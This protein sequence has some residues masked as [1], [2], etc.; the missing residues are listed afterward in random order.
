MET[1]DH[2]RALRLDFDRLRSAAAHDLSAP[3][4]ACPGWDLADLVW[5]VGEVHHFWTEIVAGEVQDPGDV[6][7]AT[8]PSADELLPWSGRVAD[9]LIDV[10]A[11][12]DP[13]VAVWTWAA[14]R[15]V[16]FVQR[17]MA[18]E[19][20]VHRWDA[21][22]AVGTPVAIDTDLATDGIDEF[23]VHMIDDGPPIEGR[24]I[25]E[26][27]DSGT[28][29]VV[30]DAGGGEGVG[31]I[32]GPAS[33]LLLALWRRVPLST[34]ETGGDVATVERFVGRTDLE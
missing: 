19:T 4:V 22:R 11:A 8:R 16:G 23:V 7:A 17:R 14:R 28:T 33:D 5:H 34:V 31:T 1:A 29:W 13:H 30:G 20:A 3:V 12:A 15:D 21:E 9:R 18:Q 25:I 6:I 26:A 24:V 2:L 32:V 10:L 27:A